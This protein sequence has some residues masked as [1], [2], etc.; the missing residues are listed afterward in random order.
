MVI[1]SVLAV[2]TVC[3]GQL[4]AAESNA[5]SASELIQRGRAEMA[6]NNWQAVASNFRQASE[7]EPT[8]SAAHN[9][10]GYSLA[11]LGHHQE[12]TDAF[13]RALVLDPLKTN[14]WYHLHVL[15][16]GVALVLLKAFGQG[17]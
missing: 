15:N 10:L 14:C 2:W 3:P 11:K 1:C 6:S 8:N 12:A 13:E 5:I 16:N 7:S 9:L 4:R 17:T